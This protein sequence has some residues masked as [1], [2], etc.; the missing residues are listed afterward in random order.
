[1]IFVLRALAPD[2]VDGS[3]CTLVTEI[4]VDDM[5]DKLL[6][7]RFIIEAPVSGGC[8]DDDDDKDIGDDGDEVGDDDGFDIM[9]AVVTGNSRLTKIS[10][11]SLYSCSY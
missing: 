8:D 9:S 6:L 10:S 3:L 11:S 4:A 2:L 5:L 1:M 7:V